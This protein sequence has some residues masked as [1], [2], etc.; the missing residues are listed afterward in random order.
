MP[1][2]FLLG[3]TFCFAFIAAGLIHPTWYW[4][5]IVQSV[6]F[7]QFLFAIKLATNRSSNH[8]FPFFAFAF[9]GIFVLTTPATFVWTP[10]NWLIFELRD[11]FHPPPE[12]NGKPILFDDWQGWFEVVG[13]MGLSMLAA[14]ATFYAAALLARVNRGDEDRMAEP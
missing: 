6:C 5:V 11:L 8:S 1:L 10:T 3:A 7:I 13:R 12:T 4:P 14:F 9:A 2:R